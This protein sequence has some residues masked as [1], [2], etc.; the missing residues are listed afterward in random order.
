MDNIEV[1]EQSVQLE[2]LTAKIL[3]LE[4]TVKERRMEED[5]ICPASD[6]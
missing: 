2:K 1:G 3:F 6:D 4:K 5:I